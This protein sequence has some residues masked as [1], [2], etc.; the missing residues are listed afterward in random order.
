LI[1]LT[2][3]PVAVA[4]IDR[5]T[6]RRLERN[7]RLGTASGAGS[8]ER[9]TRGTIAVATSAAAAAA[10]AETTSAAATTLLRFAFFA[11]SSAAFGLIGETA[12]GVASLIVCRMNEIFATIRASDRFVFVRH[13]RNLQMGARPSRDDPGL[14]APCAN[15]PTG[16]G[17]RRRGT[18]L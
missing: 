9:L 15:C 16:K 8:L 4:A 2:L 12:L 5:P 14:H 1:Y 18:V 11:A 6:L 10:T 7:R 3:R 17:E 13:E